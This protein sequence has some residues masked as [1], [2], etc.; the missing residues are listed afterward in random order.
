MPQ[1]HTPTPRLWVAAVGGAPQ[2][3]AKLI[4]CQANTYLVTDGTGDGVFAYRIEDVEAWLTTYRPLA[5]EPE[6]ASETPYGDFVACCHP[7]T[8][9]DV[10]IAVMD[11]TSLS[12]CGPGLCAEILPRC[13]ECGK[14]DT[15]IT[16]DKGIK[17]K[18]CLACGAKSPIKRKI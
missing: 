3:W 8:D 11:A 13:N 4:H 15:E 1:D 14:P 12:I 10:S 7:V 18:S 9:R 6:A 5:G 16:S 2:T 17:F